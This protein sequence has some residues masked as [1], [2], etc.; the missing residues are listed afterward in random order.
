MKKVTLNLT[1]DE[2]IAQQLWQSA[3]IGFYH[4]YGGHKR[5]STLQGDM[6]QV[7][8]NGSDLYTV[9]YFVDHI[10]S[11]IML[12]GYLEG[13]GSNVGIVVDELRDIMEPVEYIV[14]ERH[15]GFDRKTP[16]L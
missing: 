14:V 11:A 7:A 4:Q 1:I 12:K 5:F 13:I 3:C 8:M 10:T 6:A 15:Y 9:M 16:W 2:R